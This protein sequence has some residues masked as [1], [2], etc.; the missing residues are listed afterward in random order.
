ML[1]A[2]L[3]SL[4]LRAITHKASEENPI[5]QAVRKVNK[6]PTPIEFSKTKAL[7]AGPAWGAAAIA[8]AAYLSSEG[9]IS[10][11]VYE[12]IVAVMPFL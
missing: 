1:K 3:I 7:T 6:E 2:Q 10:P 9:I 4:V 8:V 12:I 11:K 5:S